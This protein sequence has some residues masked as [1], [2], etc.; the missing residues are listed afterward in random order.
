V[1]L[2][3]RHLDAWSAVRRARNAGERSDAAARKRLERSPSWGWTVMA[4][5]RQVRV[6]GEGGP[7]PLALAPRGG[8]P[9]TRGGPQA[10]CRVV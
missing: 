8:P 10:V 1:P 3:P 2:E 7:R 4:P 5:T 6:G 9:V